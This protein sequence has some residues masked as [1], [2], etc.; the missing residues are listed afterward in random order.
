MK[1][2]SV[3]IICGTRP[4][5]IKLIPLYLEMKKHPFFTAILVSSGQHK[6]ML[7]QVFKLFEVEPDYQLDAM[8][9]GQSLGA[10]TSRLFLL[11][12][13]LLEKVKPD[14]VIVQGDTTTAMA[15]SLTAF[16]HN[17]KIAHVEAGLRT[18]DK[19][20]PFPE[21]INRQVIGLAADYH[22][23]PTSVATETLKREN[24]KNIFQVGNTVIDALYLIKQKVDSQHA[25]YIKKYKGILV[26]EKKNMLITSHR[27][28]N[29]EGGLKSICKAIRIIA[30]LYS[31]EANIIFPV[32]LNP[33]VQEQ[34]RE[35]L[36]GIENIKIIEP[37]PYDELIFLM[38]ESYI[39]LT[40]SGGIQEEAP[41]LGKPIIVLRKSTER[42]EGIEAGCAVL[43]GNNEQEIL[44]QFNN[45][46]KNP[47]V[48]KKMAS[49]GCPYGDGKACSYII[50]KLKTC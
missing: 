23:T 46:Y 48:Y 18:Y 7:D 12:D 42:P 15:A 10:L 43:A 21:E 44:I 19:N 26:P 16:Y 32:H 40:D 2:K 36:S 28:E 37:V 11:I 34:V 33:K 31:K 35:S 29:L 4:E 20:S 38:N 17:V 24:K 50:Q 27:R 6:E 3:I 39:I 45:I 5:A 30:T 9:K 25:L 47:F 13:N 8:V 49:A 22:F 1:N 14:I 41:A